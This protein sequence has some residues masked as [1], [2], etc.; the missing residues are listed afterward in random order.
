MLAIGNDVSEFV[1]RLGHGRFRDERRPTKMAPLSGLPVTLRT[2]LLEYRI[3]SEPSIGRW[4]LSG[5]SDST[6]QAR[7][8]DRDLR[9]FHAVPRFNLAT[10]TKNCHPDRTTGTYR[11]DAADLLRLG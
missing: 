8:H 3:V 6:E 4:S 11:F 9:Y 1:R 7:E 10:H 2:V 5:C